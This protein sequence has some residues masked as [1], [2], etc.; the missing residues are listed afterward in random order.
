MLL[1]LSNFKG[2]K[3]H[4]YCDWYRICICNDIIRVKIAARFL[5]WHNLNK[6]DLIEQ[7]I[8]F[9]NTLSDFEFYKNEHVRFIKWI[10]FSIL[11]YFV[12]LITNLL[13]EPY[14][15]CFCGSCNLR[16]SYVYA[17]TFRIILSK[18]YSNILE[19]F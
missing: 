1:Y 3:R 6:N 10:K 15:S 19:P 8:T 7:P 16:A 13:F 4:F 12:F 14:T 5:M 2:W 11:I 9:T 17:E 18:N